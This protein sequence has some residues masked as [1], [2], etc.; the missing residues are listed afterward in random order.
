M[1]VGW[2][3]VHR[4]V[5]WYGGS[6]L[7]KPVPARRVRHA[8][9]AVS[10]VMI[11]SML[12]V[13]IGGTS[14]GGA[15]A[16]QM[17]VSSKS[18]AAMRKV[19]PQLLRAAKDSPDTW[20]QIRAYAKTGTDLSAYMWDA[21]APAYVGPTG[22]T[23]IT[24]TI[25]AHNV[26]KLAGVEGVASVFPLTGAAL[27]D[28]KYDENRT[29]AP[30][31]SADVQARLSERLQSG[32]RNNYPYATQPVA[33]GWYDVL[34][35]HDSQLAWEK[36]YT[37][38]GVKVMVN[39]SG[40]DFAHPD[41]MGTQAR[42]TDPSSPY[43]GWPL[44]FDQF[45]MYLLARDF[46]LGEANIAAGFGAYADT[47]TVVTDGSASYQPVDADAPYDYTLTGT[48]ISGDYHIGTHPDN[49]LRQWYRLINE[50]DLAD[51][52]AHDER[53]AIL[54]ADES[55]AGV[56]DTVYV[57]L[58]FNNDFTDEKP[59]RKGD[60]IGGADWWGAWNPETGDFDPEPDGLYDQSAGMLYWIADG[61]NSVPAADW[62]WGIGA[63]GNGASDEGDPASGNLVLFSVQDYIASPGGDHGQLCASGVAAQ[64]ITNAP[65]A[66][67]GA[68]PTY[69]PEGT[70]GMVTAAGKGVELINAGDFY[71]LLG[72]DAFYFAALGYDGVPGTDDDTQIMSNSW[73]YSEIHNDGWDQMSREI[74][75]IVRFLN[76]SLLVMNSAGNGA[77]G[78][79]TT[80]HPA[81]A[82]GM[83]I[84]ASTQYGS[85][86]NFDSIV[87]AG[88]ITHGDVVS[89]SGRG[90]G[91]RGD[92]GISLLGNGSVGSG[93]APLNEFFSGA[94]SW[95]PWGGTSRSTPVAAGNAALMYQAYYE[96][97]G[98]WPDFETAKAILMSGAKDLNYD[99][100][101]QGAG[102]INGNRAVDIA[103][104]GGG[105]Y[106][107][108]SEWIAGSWHGEEYP[109]F[110]NIMKP[111][112]TDDAWFEIHNPGDS[113][114]HFDVGSRWLLKQGEWT[115]DFTSAP[116]SQEPLD[117]EEDNP[118]GTASSLNAPHYLWNITDL[119][120]ESTDV[121][122]ARINVPY[123][124]FDP[125][126]SY[127]ATEINIWRVYGYDWTDVNGDGNLWTDDNGDGLVQDDE[128]DAGEYIRFNYG[129]NASQANTLT[130]QNPRGR[131]TDGIFLGLIHE[132]AREDVPQTNINML[133]EF[134]EQTEWDWVES[135]SDAVTVP[136]GGSN[137]VNVRVA[138]P[139]DAPH[140]A[141]EGAIWFNDGY[142]TSTVPVTINVAGTSNIETGVADD[143][144]LD[145]EP[146]YRNNQVYGAQAWDWRQESGDW[147]FYFADLSETP[148]GLGQPD[149]GQRYFM[150]D[151]WWE[152]MPTDVNVHIYGPTLDCFTGLED[153]AGL[154]DPYN[155]ATYGP[156][157]LERLGGS[158]EFYVGSGVFLTAT[159][160]GTNREFVA[161]PYVPGLNEVMLDN[162]NFASAE[163]AESFGMQAGALSVSV[164][165]IDVSR[166][167]GN[168][169]FLIQEQ[170]VSTM[171]LSGLV[172]QGFGL[173]RP[174]VKTG[175]P[176]S[177]D[178][179][180]DPFTASYTEQ[181]TVGNAGLLDI[182]TA[183]QDGDDLDIYLLYDFNGDGEFT[184]DELVGASTTPTAD[185]HIR[186]T[187]PAAGEYK[188]LV[189]GW[190][191]PTEESTF[192]L[193]I[194]I[195]Q[196][197]DITVTDLPQGQIIPGV[198]Y[199]FTIEFSP[200][201]V[202][203]G[204][205]EGLI[206]LGP[207]EGP[208]AIL[209]PVTY[210]IRE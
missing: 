36:G 27:P 129:Y 177:Q 30:V 79:G 173:S 103:S 152:H 205:Y 95:Y 34:G 46:Y 127:S 63:A 65:S 94:S 180:N 112:E 58:N 158:D 141:Y 184:A 170:V 25:L 78:F 155:P 21:L 23:T 162:V 146:Y 133:M 154:F 169:G 167:S 208:A 137:R 82:A 57:D 198:R 104:G 67:N 69:K 35:G 102:S 70:N 128:L 17:R 80:G 134:Y 159:S 151:S 37:G 44:Q 43:Y 64:G 153:C 12:L 96:A 74:D 5:W 76:P 181:F 136:A 209:I 86:G 182:S 192:D 185:E 188:L 81:P 83:S 68:Y 138:V 206:A 189:Q 8:S 187:L 114:L 99:P 72:T 202:E 49:G 18:D 91:A 111:G 110:T 175:L 24:G 75:S 132:Q 121:L 196:G 54:V 93:A 59:L 42:V 168:P 2:R 101:L 115:N 3:Y 51:P 191:I 38:E 172:V 71:S 120:P 105:A 32:Q 85:T 123:A 48:S 143:D 73:G 45:S 204:I 194:N 77:P 210:E 40:I 125:A 56:Y 33:N 131:A 98:S 147:R 157:T 55:V 47:S 201:G 39:D 156:Y 10:A 88:Q 140:G 199:N 6:T 166:P 122:V 97:N 118:I 107:T 130:I 119:V 106:I 26:S 149:Q 100:F 176:I 66:L 117:W 203:P 53:P 16:T 20:V 126:G 160:S 197:D 190:A 165:P 186:I 200:E 150:V 124:Q 61:V 7:V 84:G 1:S 113:D 174:E 52:Q 41:L 207:P 161:A 193:S 4:Q 179:P 116:I 144:T 89:W 164:A 142:W 22:Y 60:E 108:P 171:D 87:S 50:I 14:V 195:V 9:V 163:Q 178:D 13:G 109:A 145:V 11:L 28:R 139:G 92:A 90:P 31:L 183:G 148:G 19:H 29:T 135:Y 15:T 62:W